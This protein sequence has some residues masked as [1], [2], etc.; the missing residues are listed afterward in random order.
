MPLD[1]DDEQRHTSPGAAGVFEGAA[2]P[3]LK[4]GRRDSNPYAVRHQILSLGCLPIP[5]HPHGDAKIEKKRFPVKPGMTEGSSRLHQFHAS[6]VFPF[7][8]AYP[9]EAQGLGGQTDGGDIGR[10]EAAQEHVPTPAQGAVI[11]G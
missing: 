7:G 2:P 6:P 1:R 4:C 3:V 11:C 8:R 5:T 10:V 9:G